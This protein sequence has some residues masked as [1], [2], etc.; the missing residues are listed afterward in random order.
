[1]FKVSSLAVLIFTFGCQVEM[2]K[3]QAPAR[4][5]SQMDAGV[6][7]E[8]APDS[9]VPMIVE[10]SVGL[11]DARSAMPDLGADLMGVD[12]LAADAELPKDVFAADAGNCV[13]Q[14]I[15]AGYASA[16]AACDDPQLVGVPWYNNLETP[17]D[18]KTFLPFTGSKSAVT[19][20]APRFGRL[21]TFCSR[22]T[23]K[24]FAWILGQTPKLK[25][26]SIRMCANCLRVSAAKSSSARETRATFCHT[27]R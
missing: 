9:G 19:K 21:S 18:C 25:C 15:N 8:A 16:N 17:A 27:S 1:M 14:A 12:A 10:P 23:R 26:V 7:A 4:G 22:R 11:V 20:G 6:D 2:S 13:Q 5:P 3:L 24:S